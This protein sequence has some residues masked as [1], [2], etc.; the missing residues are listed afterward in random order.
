MEV[1]AIIG[2]I[3]LILI[4][5]TGGGILGW[6]FKG[7]GAIFEF[8]LEGW[9]SCLRVIVWIVIIFFVLLALAL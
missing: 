4:A 8:L 5:F 1:L 6:L 7:L 9:G 2:I 3:V